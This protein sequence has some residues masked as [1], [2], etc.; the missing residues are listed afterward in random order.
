[1]KCAEKI[2]RNT[3]QIKAIKGQNKTQNDIIAQ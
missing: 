3:M 2:M 1:M